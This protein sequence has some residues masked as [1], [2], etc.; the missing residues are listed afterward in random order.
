MLNS[1][2]PSKFTRAILLAFIVA[3]SSFPTFAQ[4][5]APAP[6]PE[7]PPY[8]WP[9]S[10]DYDVQHYRLAVSFDWS[11]E[12]VTG[13]TTITFQPFKSDFKEVEIDAGEMTI[14]SVK[15]A[16]G[17]PLK[18]RYEGNEKLFVTLD[19]VYP[20]GRDIAITIS[21]TAVPKKG[22]RFIT[23]TETDPNR[24]YQIW[25][26]GETQT[27][28]YWF[29]CY[30]YPNDKATSE[31]I[32]TVDD[33]YQVISN[34]ALVSVRPDPV[35]KTRTW[36]WKM[37]Q[38]FSSYL[39]SIIVGE[40]AEIKDHFKTTP[41]ISYGYRD[42]VE[43]ARL[44]FSK[45][46]PMVAFFSEKI[47]YDYPYA[48]YA[49]TTVRDFGGGMENI[50]ATTLTDTTVHD[51]R[52]HL[53]FSSDGLL[54]HELAHQWFGDLLTCRD[55]GEIWL[56]EGF[57]TFFANVWAEHDKGKDDY[58]Y[59]LLG[60]Q[61]AYFQ[62]WSR[63]NRRPIVVKR[64]DDPDAVFDTYAYP[65]GG[66]VLSMLRFVLGEE[67]FWKAI[68][69]Y[70]EQY[71]YQAVET[72]QFVIAIEEATGQNLQW[73]FDEWVYKMGHPEF[74]IT[75]KYNDSAKMLALTVKQTQKPDDKRPWFQSPDFFTMPVDIA[76]TTASGEKVHRVWVDKAEKEFTFPVDS[77]PL[78]INFD[79]GNYLIKQVKFDRGDDELAYQ[80]LHDAD[81][82]GRVR[83]AIELKSRQTDT[84]AKALAEAA[85]RDPFWAVRSEAVKALSELKTGTARAALLEAVK[86]KDSR[87]RRAAL[88]GLA[89]FKDPKLAELFI[90]IIN[91]DPSY[92]AVTEAARALGQ[93]GAP[94]A[95]DVLVGLLNQDSWQDVIRGGA[96]NALA[97]LKDPRGLDIAFKYAMPGNL[98][99]V[100]RAALQVLGEVGKGNDRALEAL[101]AAL[102]ESIQNRSFQVGFGAIQAL[103]ALG[104][105]RAIPVL[106]EIV[107]SPDLPNFAKQSINNTI[108]QI[109]RA[110][111]PSEK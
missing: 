18:F 10:H 21:Y 28:H 69:H 15:L 56:N 44:S 66:A 92:F 111:G 100:R 4:E 95:Y 50:S 59:E 102:K 52:A 60:D 37:D 8:Q 99:S 38:P 75:L 57:A 93:S 86:D 2:L 65:R 7:P 47:G 105:P 108:N 48:K 34:G 3:L 73:F 96:L 39:T 32:A 9:R 85:Q 24:P 23:P 31:I 83:A 11:K 71:A 54:S 67:L 30:D 36:H 64:Y 1:I 106:E 12:S 45:I 78:I 107:K 27:N 82:M 68:H 49:Q 94:Q 55:W 58:L 53:D 101:L 77:K 63:G 98:T 46:G 97:S 79:R 74:E 5:P 43:N 29:P 110:N 17:A 25:S 89:S 35:K 6:A 62:A 41:V 33:K 14:N 87:I 84:V 26:Q 90:T 20:A 51:Q 19:Y 70:V 80:L 76:I 88:Q 61:Q 16:Q 42:Q 104:D 13:E 91:T 81:A 103:G 109:K 40:F 72:P 22:L